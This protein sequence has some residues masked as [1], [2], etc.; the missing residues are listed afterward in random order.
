MKRVW[1]GVRHF[2]A[3]NFLDAP[4]YA[5]A[6]RPARPD[7]WVTLC[8]RGQ[9]LERVSEQRG[10]RVARE[11]WTSTLYY[12]QAYPQV[13]LRVLRAALAQWPVA[14]RDAPEMRPG[15]PRV[16]FII[17]HRGRA[18]LP[19]LLTTLRSLAAQR[20]ALMECLV[21]E[22]SAVPELSSLLPAWV[23]HLHTP[24]PYGDM[25]YSRSWAFNCGA[26][27]ARGEY[28]VFHDND[29]CVPVHYAREV[30]AVL[31]AGFEAA[32][33]QR[34][35][36]Y[37][38]EAHSQ[39]LFASATVTLTHAPL[40]IMQNGQGQTIAVRRD[41]YFDV[42]GHDE[43]FLGWGGEDNEM[44]DRLRT[45]RLHDCSYLPF[46][47]LY[48]DSQPGKGS[49]NPNTSYFEERMRIPP[50]HRIAELERRGWGRPE[51]PVLREDAALA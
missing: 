29:I 42:G 32:R 11:P 8:N 9:Q 1:R 25:P 36:F 43:A 19:H 27:E 13:G 28:L 37:L 5:R 14:F 40:T 4:R 6:L 24:L 3:A 44:F 46:L 18:R 48:H 20:D 7:G 26:R 17:G 50:T 49:T 33:F 16:S 15:P 51:G 12:P 2:L 35:V 21:V 23:R 38:G 30:A 34:F 22:Q 31:G 10:V 45:R 39:E 41:A 47:H